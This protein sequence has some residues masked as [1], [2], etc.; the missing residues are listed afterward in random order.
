MAIDGL[1]SGMVST[2]ATA[3]TPA[4]LSSSASK[5]PLALR[6]DEHAG[7]PLLEPSVLLAQYQRAS[8]RLF[9]F[10][11][12]GTLTPIV[13]DPAAAIPT[14][15]IRD[16]IRRLASDTRNTVWI[17]SGRDQ[18]FLDRWMGD[19]PQ[20]GLSAEHGSFV[21]EPRSSQ[22][23]NLAEQADMGWQTEVLDVFEKYTKQT[24]GSFI[25]KKRIAVTWHY[26]SAD[27]DLGAAQA[28]KCRQSLEQNLDQ[29][30]EVDVM[31][32]KANLEVR[33]SF[34]SKGEIAKRL[35]E[36]QAQQEQ[37][38]NPPGLVLCMG[39]DFTDEDMFRAL[40]S[41]TAAE[42]VPKENIFTVTIGDSSKVT[43]AD[44]HLPEPADVIR[45]IR[46]LAYDGQI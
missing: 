42:V 27:P 13:Q 6:P 22:W 30:W 19:I 43:A 34:I 17:I 33:P 39:D 46:L 16:T 10:D 12:D 37:T 28:Q 31:S 9:M 11:Y 7:T 24:K 8:H 2:P 45:A 41:S 5:G 25:E 35:V 26:R 15:E 29:R 4:S 18:V 23:R 44:W 21:R 38:K 32:G 36:P 1:G 14:D 3:P 20:L 40:H